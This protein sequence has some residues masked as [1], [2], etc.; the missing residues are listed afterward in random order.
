MKKRGKKNGVRRKSIYEKVLANTKPEFYFRLINGQKI[1]NL[2]GLVYALD[3]VSDEIF[4]HHV[5]EQRNDFSNWVRD[6]FKQK[7]LA[8]DIS[9]VRSKLETQ[10]VLL[11][12]IVKKSK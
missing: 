12:F 11:K 3:R 5:N 9:K 2:F 4:Y 1:K 8:E 10:V 7:K 6:I